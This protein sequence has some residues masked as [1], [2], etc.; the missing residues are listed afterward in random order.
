MRQ[1]WIFSVCVLMFSCTPKEIGS[2]LGNVL[3]DGSGLTQG[4]AGEGMK[5]A[6]LK[7]VLNGVN[8]TSQLDGF[9]KNAA[10]KILFPPEAQKVAETL[11]KNGLGFLTDELIVKMNRA[12]EDAAKSAG[13][14][15]SSA[16][17]QLTFGDAL[18]I[19]MGSDTEA[20]D[21]LTRTTSSALHSSFNPII[22]KSLEKVQVLQHW[23]KVASAYNK[24]RFL[25][26][27]EAVNPDLNRYITEKATSGLFH[28]V[29]KEEIKI[30]KDPVE[31]TTA[32]LKKVFGAQ[33]NRN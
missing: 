25:T 29:A 6:L 33:D 30:R 32:L 17:K 28:M 5:E 14:I 19:L 10:I 23:E 24:I 7:G 13:P 2:V 1:I 27:G 15:F 22:S 9:Y 21:F 16:V 11:D 8:V 3:T 18:E 20:T 31:R 12:A 4:E 26:G